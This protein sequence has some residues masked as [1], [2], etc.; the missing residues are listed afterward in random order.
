MWGFSGSPLASGDLLLVPVS[1]VLAGYDRA[2]GRPRWTRQAASEGY[3]SPQL[4]TIAGVPQVLFVSRAGVSAMAPADGT[5]LW[6]HAWEGTPI[7]QPAAL[8]GDGVLMAGGDS[9]GMR[10]LAIQ[11]GGSGW[12]AAERWTSRGLKPFFN[13]FVVHNGHAYGFDGSILSCISLENGER[14]WKGG[15]YG[16]GQLVLLADQDAL[17]VLSEEGEIA[18]VKATPDGFTELA[19]V[20]GLEGKTWNH[21][22]VVGDVLLARNGEQMAAFRLPTAR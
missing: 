14:R 2:T 6:S 8:A 15:R 20:P 7:V 17:L 21:P 3:S 18:L 4:A 10:R 1:N 16:A 19:R 11:H 12:T 22:V 13:D 9:S 5:V